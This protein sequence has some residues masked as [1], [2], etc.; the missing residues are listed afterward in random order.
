MCIEWKLISS[1]A[2]FFPQSRKTGMTARVF[3]SSRPRRHPLLSFLR[4]RFEPDTFPQRQWFSQEDGHS[5]GNPKVAH[6]SKWLQESSRHL[7]LRTRS[8]KRKTTSPSVL[9][10]NDCYVD[11]RSIYDPYFFRFLR[12]SIRRLSNRIDE[13]SYH[14]SH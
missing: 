12:R 2:S 4:R 5:R 13:A 14:Y 11:G 9:S 7:H 8:L 3:H 10:C 6:R 1:S